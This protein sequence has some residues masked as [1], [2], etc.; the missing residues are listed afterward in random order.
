MAIVLL[1]L[2]SFSLWAHR[3]PQELSVSM[4]EIRSR[5]S[6]TQAVLMACAG[7][8]AVSLKETYE[9]PLQLLRREFYRDQRAHICMGVHEL[10]SYDG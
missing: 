9:L 7:W 3:I 6:T 5:P 8:W 10:E 1:L 2:A 4:A